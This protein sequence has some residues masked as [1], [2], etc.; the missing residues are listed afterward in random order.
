MNYW[1]TYNASEGF[2]GIQDQKNSEDLL[3]M[4]DYGVFYEFIPM[5]EFDK[6]YPQTIGLSDVEIGKNYA[7]VISTNS[8]LW[9]YN[10]G[11]TI[12]F[13]SKS[14]HRIRISGRTKHFINAFGEEVIIENAE[15]AKILNP[16][17]LSL[18]LMKTSETTALKSN[19]IDKK[20]RFLLALKS[21]KELQ[22]DAKQIEQ[23][24]FQN[25]LLGTLQNIN[26]KQEFIFYKRKLD[27]ILKKPQYGSLLKIIYAEES[28]E[29]TQDD[30]NNILQLKLA[31]P[32][33]STMLY[34]KIY[35]YHL[36]KNAILDKKADRDDSK[37]NKDLKEKIDLKFEPKILIWYAITSNGVYK[38]NIF[39]E[40]IKY[41][42]ELNLTTIQIDSLLSNYKKIEQLKLNDKS[43]DLV[44]KKA[45]TQNAIEN[46][47]IAKI[48]DPK[49][50]TLLLVHKNQKA[51][52]LNAQDDWKSLD[53]IGLTKDLD[54]GTT[55]KEFTNYHIKYLVADDRVKM[56]K[57]KINVFYR[58]DILLKKPPLLKQLDDIKQSEQKTK[59]TKNELRW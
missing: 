22:L 14:P 53:K 41:Q 9:R 51:A 44:S 42:K 48:L 6:E 50:L 35:Q 11:D 10:I 26:P 3:L 27:S 2:F 57:N 20:N 37:S 31:T 16:K 52:A 15:I 13:T 25:Y 46:I 30:W 12:K 54:K 18:L 45:S 56:D 40:S 29:Q 7:M 8:G 39:S 17:Q 58:R 55:L 19:P 24:Q 43:Q 32:K 38:N 34:A 28:R 36:T 49:Q 47:A 21:A 5:E 1:E 33:D 59:N 23:I 4:L